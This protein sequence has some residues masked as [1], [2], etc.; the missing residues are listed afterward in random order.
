MGCPKLKRHFYSF[1]VHSLERPAN[2][3]GKFSELFN[4]FIINEVNVF[5]FCAVEDDSHHSLPCSYRTICFK[6]DL[7]RTYGFP[8]L[9]KGVKYIFTKIF[10]LNNHLY[11]ILQQTFFSSGCFVGSNVVKVLIP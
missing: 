8:F 9:H 6:M 7:I 3:N 2:I 5:F 10:S 1:V 11:V 4:S